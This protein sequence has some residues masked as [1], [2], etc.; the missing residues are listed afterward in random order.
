[1][2]TFISFEVKEVQRIGA[3]RS[4]RRTKQAIGAVDCCKRFSEEVMMTRNQTLQILAL[5]AAIAVGVGPAVSGQVNQSAPVRSQ[6]DELL[7]EVRALRADLERAAQASMRGQ[8]LGMRLQL[9]EQRIAAISRQLS[10]VRDRIHTIAQTRT[11][12]LGP[13]KMLLGNKD[14]MSADNP[15]EFE[16]MLGSLKQQLAG[17]DK[18]EAELKAEE[19]SLTNQLQDEQ[20]RWSAFNAQIE[21]LERAGR[22]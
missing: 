13:M 10:D 3:N 4:G 11:A 12:L 9:Q 8:L 2:A 19:M 5:A 15:K 16:F 7:A 18:S 22:R 17:L 1:M 6:M 20:A 14:P 21:E